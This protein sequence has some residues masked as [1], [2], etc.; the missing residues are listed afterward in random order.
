MSL[1]GV[2]CGPSLMIDDKTLAK[3]GRNV[4]GKSFTVLDYSEA[5]ETPKS[6]Y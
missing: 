5:K 6:A 3:W 2:V 1:L 4:S